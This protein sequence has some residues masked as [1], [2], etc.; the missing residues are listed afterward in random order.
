MGHVSR[1][2]VEAHP[3]D[4]FDPSMQTVNPLSVPG[5]GLVY[6]LLQI[7]HFRCHPGGRFVLESQGWARIT[8]VFGLGVGFDLG[9]QFKRHGT[10]DN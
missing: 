8:L 4:E 9:L 5:V 1:H 6:L 2:L 7:S 10:E 3:G